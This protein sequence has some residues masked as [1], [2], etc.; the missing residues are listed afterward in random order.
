MKNYGYTT[1][2]REYV[3]QQPFNRPIYT[4]EIAVAFAEK[5]VMKIETAKPLVNATVQRNINGL[6]L[7]RYQKGIYYRTKETPFG[8]TRLN[9]GLINK[10]RYLERN[11]EIIGYETGAAFLNRIGLSTQIPRREKY[12]TNIFKHRGSRT[13][14]K[15]NVVIRKPKVA[16][17]KENYKYLQFLDAIENKD[18]ASIDNENANMILHHY[19][20]EQNFAIATIIELAGKYYNK[21]TQ[22]KLFEII[23]GAY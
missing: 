18:R 22:L 16:I 7:E 14:P 8:K 2:I 5:F 13:D 11:G 9:P 3:G 12:A 21:K 1:F 23:P 20:I 19:L 15:L 6:G 10:T 17:N 4:T